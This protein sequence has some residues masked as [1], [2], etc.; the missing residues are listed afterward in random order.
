MKTIISLERPIRS[1]SG[2]LQISISI[3]SAVAAAAALV[4]LW[5]PTYLGILDHL[6][7]GL[8]AQSETLAWSLLAV[9]VFGWAS[10]FY[11]A[12]LDT[13]DPAWRA[14]H[15]LPRHTQSNR[16]AR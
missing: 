5:A 1:S 16:A 15:G 4:A 6:G 3:L 14:A 2:R 7:G 11:I 12:W 9:G 13:L 8:S 10:V